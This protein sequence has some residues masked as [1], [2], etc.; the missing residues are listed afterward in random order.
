M[1]VESITIGAYLT[2]AAQTVSFLFVYYFLTFTFSYYLR[3][4]PAEELEIALLF[5]KYTSSLDTV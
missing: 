1:S 2:V 5:L 3:L 4:N